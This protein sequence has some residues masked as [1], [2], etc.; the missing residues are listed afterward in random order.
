MSLTKLKYGVETDPKD[1]YNEPS[2]LGWFVVAVVVVAAISFI[3]TVLGRIAS[4]S[5]EDADPDNSSVEVSGSLSPDGGGSD[6]DNGGRSGGRGNSA[7]AEALKKVAPVEIGSLRGRSPKVR[8]LLMRLE[9]SAEAGDIEMQIS[10]IEQ[11]RG[12]SGA[13][14]ADIADELLPRLGQL[15]LC[16]LFDR[17]NPEWV[18]RVKVKRG[19]SASRIA[20]EYG[21]TLASFKRLNGLVDASRLVIGR[22][23]KVM[24]HPKF[25]LVLHSRLRVVDLF[26]NG[27]IFKRYFIDDSSDMLIKAGDYKTPANLTTYF[28]QCGIELRDDDMKELDML[29]PAET[30]F[31]VTHS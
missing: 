18:V 31:R 22:E 10:A 12:L 27:K 30:S 25:K 17:N 6:S 2:G 21:S 1:K 14:T 15:N 26:L 16:W 8:S 28:R 13:D 23:V 11:I 4:A 5:K 7:T 29:V 9:K 3:V 24:N 19:D 20:R